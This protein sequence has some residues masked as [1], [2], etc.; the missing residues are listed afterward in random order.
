MQNSEKMAPSTSSTSM[1]AGEPAEMAGG[2]AELLGLEFRPPR[3][4]ESAARL[5]AAASSS[6]RWRARVITAGS[7]TA[8]ALLGALSP[9]D[10][11]SSD[12]PSP[13]L[14][15]EHRTIGAERLH[16]RGL[17][18]IDLV[19]DAHM[20]RNWP[21]IGAEL[22]IRA[23]SHRPSTARDRRPRLGRASAGCPPPRPCLCGLAYA[24][25]VGDA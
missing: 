23:R 18:E 13:G 14:G 25:G 16:R 4:R 21:G 22:S 10:Q 9:E 6:A 24:R 15:R 2:D 11:T 20:A 8:S 12:T 19:D 5:S 7:P 1:R 17:S 3:S